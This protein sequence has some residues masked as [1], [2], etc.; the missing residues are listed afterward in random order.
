MAGIWYDCCL[1]VWMA[2]LRSIRIV[3]INM[4]GWQVSGK[5]VVDMFGSQ[6]LEEKLLLYNIFGSQGLEDQ[7]LLTWLNAVESLS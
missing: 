5:T 1:H 3:V 4:F 2:D 7:L 6:S